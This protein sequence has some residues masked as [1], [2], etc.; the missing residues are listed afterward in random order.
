MG[1]FFSRSRVATYVLQKPRK[2]TSTKRPFRIC[3]EGNICSGKS[4]LCQALKH[5]P[6]MKK[7]GATVTLEPLEEWTKALEL[8]YE[9][10]TR[11]SVMMNLRAMLSMRT[12]LDTVQTPLHI[13]ERSVHSP[14]HVFTA[15]VKDKL[16]EQEVALLQDYHQHMGPPGTYDMI[17]YLRT[18]AEEC[19]RRVTGRGTIET[20][21]PSQYFHD[22]HATHEAWLRGS[23]EEAVVV[24][25][26]GNR[27]KEDVLESAVRIIRAARM[28]G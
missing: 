7:M 25:I 28:Q 18:P 22:I 16:E 8:F 14:W 21:I 9:S 11:W 23:P 20:T 1:S 2:E 5:H 19:L 24:I 4:T 10:P 15:A 3:I 13:Q 12:A 27:T 26:N 6:D 17:I